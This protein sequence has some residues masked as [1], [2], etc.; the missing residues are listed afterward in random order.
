MKWKDRNLTK[1]KNFARNGVQFQASA[2]IYHYFP[3]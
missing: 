1:I 3:L 2:Q